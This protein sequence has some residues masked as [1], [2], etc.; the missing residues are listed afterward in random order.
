M[1]RIINS[2]GVQITEKDLSLRIETP[3]GTQVFVPG[4]AA[5]G[6]TSEPIM[7]TSISEF[8]SIYG[9]PTNAAERY[10]YY[11]CKE[12]LNSPAI[13]NTIRLPYGAEGGSAF[14]S[15][16][17]GLFYPMLS[18]A[19][20]WEI[21]APVYK[22]LTQD[23]YT[24]LTQNNFEWINPTT[25]TSEITSVVSSLS[26]VTYS[27][28][29]SATGLAFALA[30]DIDGQDIII[31]TI[32]G[33]DGLS[34]TF[35]F[36]LTGYETTMI[37]TPEN[38]L[39]DDG[40]LSVAAGFFILNDLQT[41]VNEV[42]EGYYIG[43]ADN[44][45]TGLNSLDYDSIKTATTLSGSSGFAALNTDRLDFALSASKAAADKGLA[46]ISESL[47]K[48]GFL[49]FETAAYQDHLSLGVFKIR[50]SSADASKLTLATTE[51]FLGSLNAS[52]KQ[53]SPTGG[54]LS[55]AYV[56]DIVNAGSSVIKLHINPSVS[57][58]YSWAVNSTTPT[59]RVTVSDAAKG[60]FPIGVY[61]PDSLAADETKQIGLVPLKLEK[62]LRLIENP[63]T[64]TVDVLID[65]G[66]STIY[67]TTKYASP[68]A[69][70]A[71]D[72]AT[73]IPA[74]SSVDSDGNSVI[75]NWRTVVNEL[76]NF[77]EN[78]RKDCFTIV[79]PPRSVF[80]SGKSTKVINIEGNSFTANIYNP[81]RQCVDSIETNYAATYANW[82]KNTDVFTG[83]QLWLPFSGYAA[84]VFGRSDAAGNTWSAPAG[85]NRGE[86]GNALD[87]AFNP[88]QKQR[89]RL[90][91]I[92]T[93]PVVFFNGD[94]FV[95]FGQ[96]TFQNKPTAFDRIN[97]RRLFLTLERAVQ[98][99]TKYFV[100]EPNTQFTRK[101]LVDTIS[102]I[103]NYAKNTEGLY[104]YLIV[105]DERNN[106]PDTIDNN[107]LI[108]DI[109]LKP[110]RTAEFILVNFIAT[111]TGQNF[112]ELI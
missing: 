81:L 51:K 6:P 45:S 58:G 20:E 102:P 21:G 17:S 72:D 82:I 46:S 67:S 18:S 56:E 86:F 111:R 7:I 49:S 57:T 92:A 91:E 106:T 101:R 112:Q 8:E 69:A 89:D 60:L 62:V 27:A 19:G 99:T 39:H 34:A 83:R 66:I 104:D 78:T 5:Q 10:F 26:T 3:A 93:N 30:N 100:F 16:Y 53:V 75:D 47:E 29:A 97:V 70:G 35:T 24:K 32:S 44:S 64:I 42:A 52:R 14:S 4:F 61:A 59:T 25:A 84:A 41:V 68:S 31:S 43:F 109:Y 76:I 71:F 38:L 48:V 90:Y 96:K 65:A 77:S 40:E 103:F 50:R 36:N 105:S 85:F 98:R 28:A 15:N 22:N 37:A 9:T 13:L 87:L 74:L 63:E 55:N 80:V 73:Y 23:Q 33:P 2:P 79:D 95:V 108:V 1:A 54:I 107:E 12:I 110:V 94:G 88:N 11:S